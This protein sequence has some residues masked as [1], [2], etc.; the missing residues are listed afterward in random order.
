V[1]KNLK[2][3]NIK[4]L[5]VNSNR[6][7]LN[8]L[9]YGYYLLQ[10]WNMQ[11]HFQLI[12]QFGHRQRY[13]YAKFHNGKITLW[14][15]DQIG[16][17]RLKE[18]YFPRVFFGSASIAKSHL[19]RAFR[20]GGC[21]VLSIGFNTLLDANPCFCL[22]ISSSLLRQLWNEANHNLFYATRWK[23]TRA[24]IYELLNQIKMNIN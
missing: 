9:F 10:W 4:S 13:Y 15:E 16:I 21:F 5:N 17:M 24:F 8:P 1:E 20:N 2:F 23:V 14:F 6:F 22:S 18:L 19:R 12:R 3:L 7:L 11:R